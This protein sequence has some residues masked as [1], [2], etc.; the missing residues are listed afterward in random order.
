MAT[1]VFLSAE[2]TAL[3]HLREK[4]PVKPRSLVRKGAVEDLVKNRRLLTNLAPRNMAA[5]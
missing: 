1:T 2:K 5:L 4:M 3:R